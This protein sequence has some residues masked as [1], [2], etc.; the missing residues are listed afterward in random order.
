MFFPPKHRIAM[1][2]A[3]LATLFVADLAMTAAQTNQRKNILRQTKSLKAQKTK[4]VTSPQPDLEATETVYAAPVAPASAR[5]LAAAPVYQPNPPVLETNNVRAASMTRMANSPRFSNQVRGGMNIAGKPNYRRDQPMQASR[6]PSSFRPEHLRLTQYVS[7]ESVVEDQAPIMSDGEVIVGNEVYMGE[8]CG[9]CGNCLDGCGNSG[10]YFNGCDPCFDRGGCGPCVLQNCWLFRLGPLFRNSEWNF[11]AV[12][13]NSPRHDYIVEYESE[14]SDGTVR[15]RVLVKDSSYGFNFDFNV[16]LPLCQ[17]TCGLVSGQFGVRM[18]DSNFDG[19][20][21]SKES[22][23]QVF[24]TT[25]LYRRVDYGLQIGVV[26]DFLRDEW[27]VDNSVNQVRG[28]IGWVLPSAKTFG[29]RFATNTKTSSQETRRVY[30]PTR[31]GEPTRY[32]R[33]D[34]FATTMDYYRFYYQYV[35]ASG[36]TAEYF[37]GWSEQRNGIFGANWDV[38]LKEFVSVRAGFTYFGPGRDTVD[39][40]NFGDGHDAWNIYAGAVYRPRGRGWYRCYDKPLFNVADNGTM[41]QLR[42][43]EVREVSRF[44]FPSQ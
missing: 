19:H 35:A 1:L 5:P 13:F 36:G 37:A 29:F 18:V 6:V 4:K 24:V 38:P 8:D 25:G 30:H 14:F 40:T 22:R 33:T 21:L 9:G 20:P 7:Q 3:F 15:D 11:G 28:D 39:D 27:L 43:V 12:G 42:D 44:P 16:G 32:L 31:L 17:L 23:R 34:D 26:T 10:G 41:V 2:V